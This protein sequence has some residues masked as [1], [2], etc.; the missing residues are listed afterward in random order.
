MSWLRYLK[1]YLY[2]LYA[3]FKVHIWPTS[4]SLHQS[5]ELWISPELSKLW[6]LVKPAYHNST[7][8]LIG[9][10]AISCCS[11]LPVSMPKD[12]VRSFR[13]LVGW[14]FRI[15]SE[16]LSNLVFWSFFRN[17][18]LLFLIWRPPTLPHRLQCSTIGRLRLNHR[19]RYGNG[20]L[21]QAHRQQK[22]YLSFWQ[23]R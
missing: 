8:L 19:V 3:V 20:C 11:S 13:T 2:F 6:S 16:V 5:S 7:S 15:L 4:L 21:P 10:A 1:S 23:L 12:F 17:S 9:L 22:D 18:L 14:Y